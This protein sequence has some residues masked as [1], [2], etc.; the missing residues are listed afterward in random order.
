MARHRAEAYP[1]SAEYE[2]GYPTLYVL[3]LQLLFVGGAMHFLGCAMRVVDGDTFVRSVTEATAAV[4]TGPNV[5]HQRYFLTAFVA[6]LWFVLGWIQFS[7][8]TCMHYH[9]ATWEAKHIAVHRPN[10]RATGEALWKLPATGWL[11]KKVA[12]VFG[13]YAVLCLVNWIPAAHTQEA[14][15]SH[16]AWRHA[17]HPGVAFVAA[18]LFLL[19]K[20]A[21]VH[22]SLVTERDSY[23]RAKPLD[24]HQA[25]RPRP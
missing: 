18:V 3:F 7:G 9:R 4:Q 10:P 19:L 25:E 16:W 6:N 20:I 12:W 24:Q 11:R 14:M 21:Y 5:F 8:N 1:G 13:G 23:W 2:S 22:F 15:F 17:L